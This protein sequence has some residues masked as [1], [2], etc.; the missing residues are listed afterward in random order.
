LRRAV[1]LDLTGAGT[2]RRMIGDFGE[3]AGCAVRRVFQGKINPVL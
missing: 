1:I 2:E 3:R